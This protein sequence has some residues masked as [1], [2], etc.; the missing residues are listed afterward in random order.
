MGRDARLRRTSG[1]SNTKEDHRK[2]LHSCPQSLH[3]SLV[4]G[5]VKRATEPKARSGH[6]GLPGKGKI[7]PVNESESSTSSD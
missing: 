6:T 7:G 4:M 5:R 1:D 2:S 3:M